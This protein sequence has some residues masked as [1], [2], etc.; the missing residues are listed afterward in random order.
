MNMKAKRLTDADWNNIKTLI[1][2]KM[3]IVEIAKIH[4]VTRNSIYVYGNRRGWFKKKSLL[5]K[6]FGWLKR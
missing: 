2:K 4:R 6:I 3:P 1:D 5:K